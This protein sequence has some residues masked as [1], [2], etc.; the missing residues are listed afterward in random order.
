MAGDLSI[1]PRED[2]RA[3][4][5][6]W[7]AFG[8]KLLREGHP[9]EALTFF[10]RMARLFPESP[11]ICAGLGEAYLARGDRAR[12]L[13]SF[14]RSGELGRGSGRGGGSC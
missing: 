6:E 12:A 13:E 3:V 5:G 8:Q 9:E 7:V 2:R 4:E 11:A 1:P 10:K 14:Q